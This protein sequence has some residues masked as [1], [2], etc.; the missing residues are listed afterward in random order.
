MQERGETV[1]ADERDIRGD[2]AE[3]ATA[4]PAGDALTVEEAAELLGCSPRTV[5]RW[6][7]E[8]R[9]PAVRVR[10]LRGPELRLD[11]GAV[12]SYRLLQ[13]AVGEPIAGDV[14]RRQNER[15]N[16][17][18]RGAAG[19]D[20]QADADEAAGPVGL[21]VR[22]LEELL[23]GVERER[24]RAQEETLFLRRELERRSEETRELRA[25]LLVSQARALQEV[26]APELP[27]AI[28]GEGSAATEGPAAR[29]S[30]WRL[31]G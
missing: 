24:D 8:E 30:W 18:T 16:G 12:L 13:P 23:S 7:T 31:W 15:D 14:S 5:R 19:G 29:R 20:R 6:V 17:D 4:A 3:A 10:G 22:H 1:I 21:V 11:R 2:Q 27:A 28:E 9:L 25:L 26:Q